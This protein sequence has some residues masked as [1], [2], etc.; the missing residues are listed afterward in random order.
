M[1]GRGGEEWGPECRKGGRCGQG[2]GALGRGDGS[3]QV[4]IAGEGRG[5]RQSSDIPTAVEDVSRRDAGWERLLA[6]GG[7]LN[8]VEARLDGRAVS[9]RS[10]VADG[11]WLTARTE[12]DLTLTPVDCSTCR[13]F[14]ATQKPVCGQ[15]R[16]AASRSAGSGSAGDEQPVRSQSGQGQKAWSRRSR[17]NHDV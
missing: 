3:E 10:L 9:S 2:L 5:S 14:Y 12:A 1:A 13:N 17:E 7:T 8:A 15:T 16:R 11:W 4:A 6:Q